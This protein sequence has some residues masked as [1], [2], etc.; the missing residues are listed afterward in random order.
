[1]GAVV[2][3]HDSDRIKRLESALRDIARGRQTDMSVAY[4]SAHRCREIARD[5]LGEWQGAEAPKSLL[6]VLL[7][8]RKTR[9]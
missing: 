3:I 7:A 5:A 9:K 2:T 6:A 8:W 1:V 4:Y